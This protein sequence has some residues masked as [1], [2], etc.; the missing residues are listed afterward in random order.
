MSELIPT[1]DNQPPS[2]Q[3]LIYE[4][5]STN[6][7]VLLEGNTV[8]LTQKLL[9]ELYQVSVKTVN[10]HLIN[11]YDE[12]EIDPIPTIRKFRIVQ[13]EGSRQVSRLIDHYNLEAIL[14]VGYRVRSPVGTRL[15][16]WATSRLSELLVKGFTMDDERLKAGRSIGEDYFEELLARIR[17]IRS[18]ERR[19]YQKI[20]DI[21]ATSIDYKNDAQLTQ[22]F[23]ATVQNKLEWAITG[24]TAA[25]IIKQRANA[26]LPHMGLATWKNAP[27]GAVRKADVTIAKNYLTEDELSQLNRIVTMYLDFAEDQARRKKTMTMAQWLSKLDAFLEFNDRAVLNHAGKIQKKVAD[28]LAESEFEKYQIEQRHIAATTPTSDF[29]H[30]VEQAKRIDK[31]LPPEKAKK[32]PRRKGNQ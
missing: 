1:P 17:D 26:A 19:F 23:F 14:A 13:S 18:S 3:V 20:T 32:S 22:E 6:L 8:W 12:E 4:D 30:F 21:Y 10:E 15:R 24:M 2:G 11:I 28:R 16:Q 9:A 25:E 29:D 5:G 27:D 31:I 7:R